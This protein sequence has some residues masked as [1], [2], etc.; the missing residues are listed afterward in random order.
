M[1]GELDP[2]IAAE[3]A[4]IGIFS[5]D[6]DSELHRRLVAALARTLGQPDGV[7]LTALRWVYAWALEQ[8]GDGLAVAR[9]EYETL[10]AQHIVRFRD[11]GERSGEMASR[12]AEALDEVAAAHLRWRLAEQ[13]ER[14]ARKR[15]DACADQIKVWQSLNANSRAADRY[16][17]QV[18]A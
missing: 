10:L 6:P 3:L 14:L 1:S 18:G 16:H 17:A 5:P 12:R 7:R 13:R 11:G 2:R 9:A 4:E 8:E 15:L